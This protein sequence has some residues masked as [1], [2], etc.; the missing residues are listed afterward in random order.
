MLQRV[1]GFTLAQGVNLLFGGFQHFA[2]GTHLFV[3]HFGD[4]GS[5][6][7]QSP[8]HSLLPD[9]IG[10]AHHIG[11][12]GGD[13]HQLHDVLAGILAVITQLLHLVQN[14]NRV[15]GLGEIEHG[16]DGFVNLPVL[17]QIKILRT[18]QSDHIR[19]TTAVNEDGTQ[20]RLF[21]FQGLGQLPG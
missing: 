6:S 5:C 14:G 20:N 3:N 7:V 2:G 10:I 15:N 18:E 1:A 12:C 13:L 21:R 16:I 19:D 9:D 8:E 17:L 11:G 4:L